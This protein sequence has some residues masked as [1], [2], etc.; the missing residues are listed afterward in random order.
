M[1]EQ[2]IAEAAKAL[3]LRS[4]P[5]LELSRLFKIKYADVLNYATWIAFV[6]CGK[7]MTKRVCLD[8]CAAT[9]KFWMNRK[10]SLPLLTRVL[11][12]LQDRFTGYEPTEAEWEV[13]RQFAKNGL[14]ELSYD[15]L[16]ETAASIRNTGRLRVVK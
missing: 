16:S 13:R 8:A 12:V 7:P 6:Y 1:N 11:M 4:N 14:P 5:H 2:K 3:L 15:V 10:P 9:G